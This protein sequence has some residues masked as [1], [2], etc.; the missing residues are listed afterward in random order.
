MTHSHHHH[1]HDQHAAKGDRQVFW[2]VAVNVALTVAQIIGGVMAGSLALIADAIHN[3]SDA[4][5]LGIA[6]LARRIS[7]RPADHNMT[8]GYGRAELVAALVNYT[9]LIVIAVYLAYEAV[10]RFIEPQGV[11]GWI[12][13]VVA[14]VALIVD[15]V[16]ALL[17]YRLSKDSMNIRAAFLHNLA[18][19]LGSVGVIV[20]GVLII[21]F[22]W[23]VAD[24]LITLAIAAYIFWMVATEIGG[25]IRILMLGTPRDVAPDAILAALRGL[26]GVDDVHHLHVWQLDERDNS[27]EAHIVLSAKGPPSAEVK[28]AAKALLETRFGIRHSTFE[29]EG[30][31]ED[32]PDTETVGHGTSI[33]GKVD[34]KIQ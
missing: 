3:L 30:A 25:V 33:R 19:A 18:D 12:V 22:D 10:W 6:Y 9:T 1:G 21:L 26:H 11:D 17:T 20:A 7:R 2:A 13:V 28:R 34:R 27:L 8:F 15:A 16:T 29:I 5:S 23:N 31:G 14:G 4:V 32:C 24:A